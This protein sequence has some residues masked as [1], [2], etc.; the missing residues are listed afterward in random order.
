MKYARESTVIYDPSNDSGRPR[1]LE[2]LRLRVKD[3]DLSRHEITVREGKGA[4]LSP[5]DR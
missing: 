2:C 3:A 4:V 5:L 1:L